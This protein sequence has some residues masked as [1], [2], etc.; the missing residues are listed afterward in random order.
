MVLSYG[1][2]SE[3]CT[4]RI[5][6]KGV[7]QELGL[8]IV[9]KPLRKTRRPLCQPHQHLRPPKP[10]QRALQALLQHIHTRT[11]THHWPQYKTNWWVCWTRDWALWIDGSPISVWPPWSE[12]GLHRNA[13]TCSRDLRTSVEREAQQDQWNQSLLTW[14]NKYGH[15]D[16]PKLSWHQGRSKLSD[17]SRLKWRQLLTRTEQIHFSMEVFGTLPKLLM[18]QEHMLTRS[19]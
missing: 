11:S 12:A 19:N 6:G 13:L 8:D 5:V 16:I 4:E 18:L 3:R 2:C 9:F 10:I 7:I 14:V 15:S 17:T 1:R